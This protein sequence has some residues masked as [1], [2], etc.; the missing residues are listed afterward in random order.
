MFMRRMWATFKHFTSTDGKHDQGWCGDWRG[1]WCIFKKA[2]D[3][4]AY[5]LFINYI[6]Y[7]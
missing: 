5:I 1:D 2:P 3:E 4:D 7:L 6:Y